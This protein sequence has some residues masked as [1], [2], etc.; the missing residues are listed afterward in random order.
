MNKQ[1]GQGGIIAVVVILLLI[2]G[3]YLLWVGSRETAL[4]PNQPAT[5]TGAVD[6]SDDMIEDVI[7][8]Y[9]DAG[10]SPASITI[11]RGQ[12]VRFVNQSSRDFWPA[13]AMH[14]T[15]E[16]YP[17][18]RPG[19]CLGSAFDACEAIPPGGQYSFTFNQEGEWGYHD[20][21]DAQYFGRITVR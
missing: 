18:D 15:H 8:T 6:L 21:I 13:S 17:E 19:Q 7:I 2:I 3:G 10:Y 4:E 9:T 20:H 14:P 11:N 1:Q 5:T 16:V 12:T